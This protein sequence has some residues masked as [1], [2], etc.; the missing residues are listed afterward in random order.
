MKA[1]QKVYR[2]VHDGDHGLDH[3]Q[4]ALQGHLEVVDAKTKDV[5]HSDRLVFERDAVH[6]EDDEVENE[7]HWETTDIFVVMGPWHPLSLYSPL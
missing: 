7:S 5:E 1:H 4:T 2:A 3:V 6:D